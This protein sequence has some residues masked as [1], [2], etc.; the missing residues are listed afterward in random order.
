MSEN[1]SFE[2]K[3]WSNEAAFGQNSALYVWI[4]YSRSLFKTVMKKLNTLEFMS[5]IFHYCTLN[6]RYFKLKKNKKCLVLNDSSSNVYHDQLTKFMCNCNVR[7]WR[8][9][10]NIAWWKRGLRSTEQKLLC[11]DVTFILKILLLW[12]AEAGK[13]PDGW[14][15]SQERFLFYLKQEK[16]QMDEE[17]LK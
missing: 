3:L 17:N 6:C 7:S 5:R 4:K 12:V 2:L 9:I 14:R 16:F 11:I 15:K 8:R 13:V 1:Y 10:L